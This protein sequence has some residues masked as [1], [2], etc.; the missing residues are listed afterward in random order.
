MPIEEP[1][2]PF[3]P[4]SPAL[5]LDLAPDKS[6]PV[7]PSRQQLDRKISQEDQITIDDCGDADAGKVREL[8]KLAQEPPKLPKWSN[9]WRENSNSHRCS[10]GRSKEDLKLEAILLPLRQDSSQPKISPEANVAQLISETAHSFPSD[11]LRIDKLEELLDDENLGQVARLALEKINSEIAHEPVD[12]IDVLGRVAVPELAPIKTEPPWKSEIASTYPSTLAELKAE[13]KHQQHRAHEELDLSLRWVPLPS[14]FAKVDLY[15]TISGC[16]ESVH[17]LL[18]PPKDILKSKDFLQKDATILFLKCDVRMDDENLKECWNLTAKAPSLGIA[19]LK[20]PGKDLTADASRNEVKSTNRLKRSVSRTFTV[21]GNGANNKPTLSASGSCKVTDPLACFLQTRSS[22]H[23]K[24]DH[25]ASPYFPNLDL[26]PS[27]VHLSPQPEILVPATP[28]PP[29]RTVSIIPSKNPGYPAE[30]CLTAPRTLILNTTLL[31]AYSSLIDRLETH[32][33]H[34]PKVIF[35]DIS[36]SFSGASIAE[37]AVPD[38]ILSPTTAL[39]IVPLQSVVQ[40]ALPGQGPS[41]PPTQSRIL[42]LARQ[43]PTLFVLTTHKTDAG[44]LDSAAM[45]S[46]TMLQALCAALGP[47]SEVTV[48]LIPPMTTSQE[49]LASAQL[50]LVGGER[51]HHLNHHLLNWILALVE[52]Y[53]FQ[54]G[55]ER[56]DSEGIVT[57]EESGWQI[58]LQKAGLNPF[59]AMVAL[60]ILEKA[61]THQHHLTHTTKGKRRTVG[62]PNT[63]SR[64]LGRLVQM[65]QEERLALF[66]DVIGRKAV[67][68]LG[69]M[70]DFEWGIGFGNGDGCVGDGGFGE[71]VVGDE[72]G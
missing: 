47:E 7:L 31:K 53:G 66:E 37:Q 26:E 17:P 20:H 64:G 55:P 45:S 3:V 71:D 42:S 49:P 50:G 25:I 29:T 39:I 43:F 58:F 21:D 8:L 4:S 60:D 34:P 67:E 19:V 40:R 16:K 62:L 65:S 59:A 63:E 32:L 27:Q 13:A 15:E 1:K 12:H 28:I 61:S 72:G 52:K 38:I 9:L 30:I 69:T 14:N 5:L 41:I 11:D 68:A 54:P 35:R 36:S 22:K 2:E 33:P 56:V 57:E 51:S 23:R 6:D 70:L 46:V 24:L 44:N 10:T 18:E 48:I